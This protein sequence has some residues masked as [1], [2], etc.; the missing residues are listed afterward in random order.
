MH[1]KTAVTLIVTLAVA[2]GVA[3]LFLASGRL[4]PQPPAPLEKL[5]IANIG[6]YSVYN[7]LAKEK[8]YFAANGL[9]AQVD[10]YDSGATSMGALLSGKADVAVAAEFVGVV[11]MLKSRDLRILASVSNHQVFR[12]IARRDRGISVPSDLKGRE[13]G[14]TKRTV[15][16]FYLSR[17]LTAN[18]LG[19]NDTK[20]VDLNPTDMTA[21][22]KD[23][24][25]DAIIIFEPHAYAIEKDLSNRV[26]AWPAQRGLDTMALVY[27]TQSFTERSPEL[28]SKYLRSILMAD[29]FL[30]TDEAAA[31]AII[32]KALNYDAS[33]EAYIWP[34]FNFSIGLHQ[35]M[36]LRLEDQARFL[37]ENGL[38][39]E[40]R[41]PNYLDSIYFAGMEKEDPHAVFITHK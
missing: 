40:T 3:G 9:D 35:E 15:G 10:E 24:R 23:G 8:G 22:L 27:S 32:A 25:L 38:T 37:I 18:G 6:T 13:I 28:I 39:D 34:K 21:W 11:N 30:K 31:R 4:K 20:L 33:Y 19:P 12:V 17:F 14:V 5:T 41:V 2:L 1:K 7:I 16:E 36:L 26:V 29:R